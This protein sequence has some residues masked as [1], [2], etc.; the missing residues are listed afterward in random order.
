MSYKYKNSFWQPIFSAFHTCFQLTWNVEKFVD[1]HINSHFSV[2][3][4]NASL[5]S[6]KI[7]SILVS[8]RLIKAKSK[9]KVQRFLKWPIFFNATAEEKTLENAEDV[10]AIM[11]ELRI[12][13]KIHIFMRFLNNF[14]HPT[15]FAEMLLK[16]LLL[17][18]LDFTLNEDY[19]ERLVHWVPG[20]IWGS[21]LGSFLGSIWSL[22]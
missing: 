11:R 8:S 2:S 1:V 12:S 10:E 3:W 4:I 20:S 15:S 9:T 18:K 22:N 6:W 21:P 13:D 14:F 16:P 19:L 7:S 5:D 17:G